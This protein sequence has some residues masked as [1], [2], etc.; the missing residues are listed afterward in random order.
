MR[1]T[2]KAPLKIF[3]QAI[4]V[5]TQSLYESYGFLTD[6]NGCVGRG[7]EFLEMYWVAGI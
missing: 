6:T 2:Y 3:F 5:L 7:I 1:T 4:S